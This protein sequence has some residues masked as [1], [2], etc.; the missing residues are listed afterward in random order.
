[1]LSG[2][3]SGAKAK[4][5]VKSR[6]AVVQQPQSRDQALGAGKWDWIAA[7]SK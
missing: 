5:C 4:G 6:Y 3:W 1:M 7:S 2:E